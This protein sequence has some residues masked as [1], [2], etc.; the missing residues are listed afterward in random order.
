MDLFNAYFCPKSTTFYSGLKKID[1][2][3]FKLDD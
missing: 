1:L 3:A 2:D